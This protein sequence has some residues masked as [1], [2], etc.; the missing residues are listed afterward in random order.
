MARVAGF[1]NT[2]GEKIPS[3]TAITGL[4]DK[5]ALVYWAH[6]LGIQG[7]V[8]FRQLRDAIG[9]AGTLS[10]EFAIGHLAG[11]S[12]DMQA[13]ELR[14]SYTEDEFNLARPIHERFIRWAD[15]NMPETI[16]AEHPLVSEIHQYGGRL[17]WFGL[18][19]G[20]RTLIDFKFT[21][22][23]YEEAILQVAAYRGLLLESQNEVDEV[24][25]VRIGRTEEEGQEELSPSVSKLDSAWE[26][27]LHLRAFWDLKKEFAI[28]KKKEAA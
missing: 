10:H 26:A 7:I 28:D 1:K 24:R 23:I 5:P 4:L 11:M 16:F 15:A 6:G 27:F 19:N 18:I 25:I 20:V 21:K 14:K 9:K 13:F 8:N 22:A 12:F 2:N 17:D 3:V